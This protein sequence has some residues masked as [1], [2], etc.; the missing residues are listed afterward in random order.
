MTDPMLTK[1]GQELLDDMLNIM[2]P[3]MGESRKQKYFRILSSLM[4][5]RA[6]KQAGREMVIEA[7]KDG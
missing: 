1:E 6:L 4:D 7:I 2:L 3:L 5:E